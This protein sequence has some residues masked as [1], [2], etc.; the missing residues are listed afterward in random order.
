MKVGEIVQLLSLT[1][2]THSGDLETEIKG[3]YTSDLLSNV[4]G[5]AKPGMIWVTMQGH[6]N[7]VAVASLIGLAAVIITGGT[8]IEADTITKA[9]EN[10]LT[11]FSTN[12]SSYEVTGKLYAL[13][14]INEQ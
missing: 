4:M 11:V 13:G 1:N 9:E 3:G 14:I 2:I 12:M 7:V 6:H 10:E 8:K 5:Q